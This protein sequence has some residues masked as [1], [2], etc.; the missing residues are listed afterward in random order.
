M[1]GF[2]YVHD[3]S[4]VH[5]PMNTKNSVNTRN[6]TGLA[7]VQA[8][9]EQLREILQKVDWLKGW[10]VQAGAGGRDRG[11][12][13]VATVPKPGGGEARLY[14]ESKSDLRPGLFKAQAERWLS[15]ILKS[16]T[17]VPVLAAPFVSPRM[18]ELCAELGWSWFDLAGNY[19]LDIPGLL[20]LQHTGNEPVHKEPLIGANLSTPEA[21][22]VI[23]VLLAYERSTVSWTQREIQNECKPPVSLGLVNKVIRHLS[24]EALL[25]IK[26]RGG[27][28]LRDPEKLLYAWRDAYR[29]DLHERR[30]YFTLLKGTTLAV[31]LSKLHSKTG[32]HAAYA[33]FSAAQFQAPHVKQVK[34]WLYIRRE[35][36]SEFEK[37]AE[38]KQVDSGENVVVLIPVDDGVF[39]S[40]DEVPISENRL[41]CTNPVQTYVDLY[42]VGGRGEEAAEA[43]LKQ[44][45]EPEWRS[46]GLI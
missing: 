10:K 9:A 5:V 22:R 2:G 36:I 13:I 8:S 32:G 17:D 43:L 44:R 16:P 46:R 31:E 6:L 3:N 7:L 15:A 20:H 28:S 37:L 30:D 23:R 25:E 18:S 39:Y 38:A 26:Q 35:E 40:L 27:I 34:N 19:R 42:P 1:S 45:L 4:Y 21:A 41:H 12:D 11:F 24:D 33:A 29:F 14:V